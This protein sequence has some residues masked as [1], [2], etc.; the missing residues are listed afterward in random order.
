MGERLRGDE[1]IR[2]GEDLQA[3]ATGLRARQF[4]TW[5]NFSHFRWP[6]ARNTVGVGKAS[7]NAQ[8]AGQRPILKSIP[9]RR[10]VLFQSALELVDQGGALLNQRDF[11]AA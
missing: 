7:T 6:A 3:F 9:R 10:I 1:L 8:A 11:V 2:P 5:R 4:V